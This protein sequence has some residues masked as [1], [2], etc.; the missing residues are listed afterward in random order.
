[1]EKGIR[2]VVLAAGRSTRMKSNRSKVLHRILGREI[3]HFLLDALRSC[4]IAPEDTVLVTAKDNRAIKAVVSAPVHFAVQE[5]QLGTAHALLS[6]APFL[7]NFAGD[8]LVTVG[9]NPYITGRELTRLIS[10]HREKRSV[11]TLLSAVFPQTP[12]PYGRIVRSPDGT[13]AA[14]V[15][16]MDADEAQRRIREVNAS[17]YLFDNPSVFP[18]LHEIDNH[19]RKG[20]YYLTDIVGLLRKR[21][22]AVHSVQAEDPIISIGINNRWELQEAQQ[23]F[24]RNNLRDWALHRG[25]TILQ[26]ESV[27][28][29]YDVEIGVDSVIYP[30]TYIAR[31]TRI[32][33]DCRI[34]P[35]AYLDGVT[36]ND[37]ES[38]AFERRRRE[39]DTS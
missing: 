29:E 4:G 7:K 39:P 23:R 19:N 15:E 9:D 38:V 8:C 34:G 6:A 2:A 33:R 14:V 10:A 11:C 28:I 26:P 25:V 1:M 22:D 31:G 37:S 18:L 13:V 16:E 17:I 3:I 5:E 30:S 32:G 20:E 21:G 27:T 24:N 36:V 12:P 35:F